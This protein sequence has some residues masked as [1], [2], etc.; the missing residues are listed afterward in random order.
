MKKILAAVLAG[1]ALFGA[2]AA[3]DTITN[4]FGNTLTTT[5]PDGATVRWHFNADGSYAMALPNGA[6]ATGTWTQSA[7]RLC[8]TPSDGSAQQ[9]APVV[10]GKGVGDTWTLQN[11]DG[12][13]ITVSIIAGR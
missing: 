6:S 3:A 7:E 2:V 12:Q 13:T 11:D 10:S 1:A 4:S 9:C 5:G 8:V